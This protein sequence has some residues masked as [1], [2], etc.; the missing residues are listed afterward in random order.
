MFA[1]IVFISHHRIKPGMLDNYIQLYREVVEEIQASKPGTLSHSAYTNEDGSEVSHVHVIQD[2][3]AMD[4]H[5]QGVSDRTKLAYQYIEP[6]TM[7]L[8]GPVSENTLE[9]FTKIAASGVTVTYYP[10]YHGGY[11]RLVSG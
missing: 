8:Y 10:E 3:D 11:L 5:L 1:P 4:I 9:M 2:A 6:R 7:E